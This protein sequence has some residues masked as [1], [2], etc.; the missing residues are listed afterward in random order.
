MIRFNQS[1]VK[2]ESG[3]SQSHSSIRVQET[4]YAVRPYHLILVL[5][6]AFI[7]G[8]LILLWLGKIDVE[9][10]NLKII[11]AKD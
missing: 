2:G 11:P 3:E 7:I 6:L 4:Y 10:W 5:G 1:P 9:L 8:I